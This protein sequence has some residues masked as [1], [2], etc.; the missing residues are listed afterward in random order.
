VNLVFRV[1]R[2]TTSIIGEKG[3]AIRKI[4]DPLPALP[5]KGRDKSKSY[6]MSFGTVAS[7]VVHFRLQQRS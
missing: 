1:I 6:H 2:T 7:K 3:A 5:Q 4:E